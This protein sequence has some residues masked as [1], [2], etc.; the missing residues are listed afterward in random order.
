MSFL[1]DDIHHGGQ[2]HITIQRRSRSA[3]NLDMVDFL[4]TDGVVEFAIVGCSHIQAVSVFH[5]Q[6]LFLTGRINTMHGYVRNGVS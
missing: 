5:H 4:G 2:S 6:N 1:G 3:Q